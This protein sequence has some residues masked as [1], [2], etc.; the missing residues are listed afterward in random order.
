MMRKTILSDCG[1]R[2]KTGL[3][4]S[5]LL[6]FLALNVG[7]SGGCIEAECGAASEQLR[8]MYNL[9]VEK[10]E[11]NAAAADVTIEQIC[12]TNGDSSH[13]GAFGKAK[14][15]QA[16]KYGYEKC[17]A[18]DISY[19]AVVE[20]ADLYEKASI[21]GA[22]VSPPSGE[23]NCTLLASGGS[24][25]AG[26]CTVGM[27]AHNASGAA[28]VLGNTVLCLD[29]T[30]AAF[31]ADATN[32]TSEKIWEKTCKFKAARDAAEGWIDTDALQDLTHGDP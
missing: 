32:N 4:R 13:M 23:G 9:F 1:G 6:F 25:A 26:N 14:F 29:K 27:T 12:S 30:E 3:S 31:I 19:E 5:F 24:L 10:S 11:A 16:L 22:A 21:H 15:L 20:C 7:L 17:T 8:I 28:A 2:C 18:G